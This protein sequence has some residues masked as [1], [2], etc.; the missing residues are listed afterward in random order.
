MILH[1]QSYLRGYDDGLFSSNMANMSDVK[2]ISNINSW[3]IVRSTVASVFIEEQGESFRFIDIYGQIWQVRPS[4]Y[5]DVPIVVE[6]I[7]K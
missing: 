5:R 3:N 6:R 2:P 4:G 7:E 1:K